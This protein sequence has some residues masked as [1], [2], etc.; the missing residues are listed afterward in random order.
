MP[1]EKLK[2]EMDPYNKL[3]LTISNEQLPS[4]K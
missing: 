2:D 4:Y 3:K 1:K